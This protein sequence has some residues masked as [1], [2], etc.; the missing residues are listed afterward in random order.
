MKASNQFCCGLYSD[1]FG[2]QIV[3]AYPVGEGEDAEKGIAYQSQV[4][5]LFESVSDGLS[6]HSSHR[7]FFVRFVPV[8][9]HSLTS[10][11]HQIDSRLWPRDYRG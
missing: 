4:S 8:G 2:S 5:P 10:E 9:R 6:V 11:I 7:W 3:V 1:C